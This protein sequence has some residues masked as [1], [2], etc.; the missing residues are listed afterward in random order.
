MVCGFS[1]TA[2]PLGKGGTVDNAVCK[3]VWVG[4]I[5]E[6]GIEAGEVQ[7]HEGLD[8]V[9]QGWGEMWDRTIC[10]SMSIPGCRLHQ[11]RTC[12]GVK[13]MCWWTPKH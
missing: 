1:G 9:L 6:W 3:T 8:G 2:I 11:G 5:V 4:G 12:G 10:M 7:E 13:V